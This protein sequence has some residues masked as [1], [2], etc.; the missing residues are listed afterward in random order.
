MPANISTDAGMNKQKLIL[1][2]PN[3]T[4]TRRINTFTLV[5]K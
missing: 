1:Y 2:Y 4:K 5:V 3:C